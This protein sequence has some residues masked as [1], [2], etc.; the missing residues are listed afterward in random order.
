MKLLNYGKEGILE[1]H[2]QILAHPCIHYERSRRLFPQQNHTTVTVNNPY[3]KE[4]L[5]N[6]EVI[7]N[8]VGN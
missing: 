5:L 8:Y 3:A 1:M 7:R 2:W 4:P 6:P